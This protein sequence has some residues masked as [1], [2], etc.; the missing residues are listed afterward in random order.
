MY[1]DKTAQ[2]LVALRGLLGEPTLPSRVRASTAT[3]GSAGTR[4]RRTSSTPSI[5]VAGRDLVLVLAELVL[6]GVAAR[7]G[8]RRRCTRQGDSVAITI[9]DR[10]LAPMPV[11]AG[12]HP[13]RRHGAARRAAGGRLAPWR[14]N[15]G[16]TRGRGAG[17]D[18]AWRSIRSRISRISTGRI[19]CG[20]DSRWS[21]EVDG[22]G[23]RVQGRGSRTWRT[24]CGPTPV[25]S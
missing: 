23:S 21:L 25:S 2:V 3:G 20:R 22:R 7:P 8:D 15:R 5:S 1:Y 12:S 17:G 24:E 18:E 13:R 19:R 16:R 4:S 11:R 9:E 10:G 14:P 6:P